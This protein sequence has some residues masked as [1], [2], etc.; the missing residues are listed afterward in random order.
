MKKKKS[1]KRI[2]KVTVERLDVALRMCGMEFMKETIVKIID[3][4]E[5]IENKGGETTIEDICKLKAKWEEI[6]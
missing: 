2:N 3:L 4:V 5:L 1:K 6:K